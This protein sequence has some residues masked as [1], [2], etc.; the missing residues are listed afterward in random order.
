MAMVTQQSWM[1]LRSFAELR[2]VDDD[3]LKKLKPGAFR[4][5]L[6]NT[7]IETL[8]HLGPGAF[9]EIS[10]EVVNIVLFTL[11]NI[12]PSPEHR[13]TAFRLIGPKSP[14]EKERLMLSW[15]SNT[16][17]R[18]KQ[19]DFVCILNN[20]ILYWI[21]KEI[22]K[23][24]S[25]SELFGKFADCKEGLGTRWDERF[26][27]W[28]WE[29]M[30]YSKRWFH[31]KKGGGYRK[32]YGFN[33]N[34]V[35]WEYSGFR[36]LNFFDAEGNLRSVPRNISYYFR[37]GLTYNSVARGSLGFHIKFEDTIFLD[38]SPTVFP[39]EE[40]LFSSI[41]LILNSRIFSYIS[42][43]LSPSIQFK[44]GYVTLLPKPIHLNCS[45]QLSFVVENLKHAIVSSEL[46]G[47]P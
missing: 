20:P 2:A 17:Y 31:C 35:D 39:K 19:I 25:T 32:W 46:V 9:G 40:E 14:E 11:T 13:I 41:Y 6:W 34:V 37:K 43:V 4:G 22:L 23:I 5:L 28:N 18:L 33:N 47:I 42:R 27:R 7:T 12:E 24:I 15:Q 38:A 26:V 44:I 45:K 30:E 29:S 16:L 36:I 10:G 3:K 21:D 8:A 1:F